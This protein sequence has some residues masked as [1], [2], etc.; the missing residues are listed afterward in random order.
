MR[1]FIS[2]I[3]LIV[4]SLKGFTSE[5]PFN[6]EQATIEIVSVTPTELEKFL[7]HVAQRESNNT[8]DVVNRYG[9]LGKYQF[10]PKT[11]K[12]LGYNVDKYEFLSNP[13]LQDSVMVTYLRANNRELNNYIIRYENKIY[14]GVKITRSG[15]LAAAH[16]CGS[17]NVKRFFTEPDHNGCR[18]ANNTTAREYMR[19][20]SMYNLT[21][22]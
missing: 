13:E 19:T 21:E 11:I 3:L 9:M 22:I 20:F 14:K 12:V 10:S 15:V 18:D 4:L 1:H 5:K 8:P 17:R 7:N 16:L 6:Q 2:L